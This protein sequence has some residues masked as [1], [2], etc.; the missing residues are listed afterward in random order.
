[1][2][3]NELSRLDGAS[4]SL[5]V[6]HEAVDTEDV[7]TPAIQARALATLALHH[8]VVTERSTTSNAQ[9]YAALYAPL[10]HMG[11]VCNAALTLPVSHGQNF[12]FMEL[13]PELRDLV[14]IHMVHNLQQAVQSH[15]EA[16][17]SDS[18]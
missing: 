1:M 5:S 7:K 12:P 2:A 15:M 10:D 3:I 9:V 14:Y 18:N 8:R 4:N 16:R 17:A 11:L 6:Y 13:P